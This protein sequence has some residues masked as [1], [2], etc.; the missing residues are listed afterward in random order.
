[1]SDE[2]QILLTDIERG[3][4]SCILR[5]ADKK[6]FNLDYIEMRL[7]CPCAKCR[8]RQEN[9]QLILDFEESLKR[10][11]MAKPMAEVIGRYAIR[12]EWPTGCS[13]GLYS[14]KLLRQLC[15]TGGSGVPEK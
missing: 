6:S 8:P 11:Q 15:E 2:D 12:F 14:F 10:M 4:E 9:E 3:E 5:F 7:A 1:M 13:S